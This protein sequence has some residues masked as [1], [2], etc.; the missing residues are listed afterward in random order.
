MAS[1][2]LVSGLP[3][4]FPSLPPSPAPLCTPCIAGRLRATPH[5]SSLRPATAPFQTLHLDV[6]G[7]GP[8]QGPERERYFLVVVDNFSRYTTVFPLAKKSEVTS[9][10]IRWLLATE[11]TRGR[12]VSCLHS[13]GGGDFRSGILA[14]FCG[15][16]GIVQSWTLPRSPQ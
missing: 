7:P 13:D 11:G 3:R 6:W 4:V 9:T 12:R 8:T 5:S 10:L 1:H 2:R 16:Q 15:E 14:G